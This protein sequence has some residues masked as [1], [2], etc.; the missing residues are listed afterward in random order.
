MKIPNP[1]GLRL[2]AIPLYAFLC[3]FTYTNEPP[4][5]TWLYL[6]T[7]GGMFMSYKIYQ[8]DKQ[9]MLFDQQLA[10]ST[11][12]NFNFELPAFLTNETVKPVVRDINIFKMIAS[13]HLTS[14][15]SKEEAL[16]VG[17]TLIESQNYLA[18]AK[19]LEL[20]AKSDDKI[21]I[22]KA[23][24]AKLIALS[25]AHQISIGQFD[26]Y[27]LTLLQVNGFIKIM[28]KNSNEFSYVLTEKCSDINAIGSLPE[29]Q[30]QLLISLMTEVMVNDDKLDN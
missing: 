30:R 24:L 21:I 22:E 17:Q 16:N 6:V 1:T 20:A 14:K 23:E 12:S 18:A 29:V 15:Y 8:A 9:K 3:W 11:N 2:L 7:A 4:W 26:T 25:Q 27:Q 28:G 13:G 5:P 19:W 10:N